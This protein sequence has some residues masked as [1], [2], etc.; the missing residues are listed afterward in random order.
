MS[1]EIPRVVVVGGGFGG[2][3]AAKT[4][5]H[6]PADVTLCDRNNY[7]L[8]QPLLYQVATGGLAPGEIAAPIRR[9]VRGQANISVL[10]ENVDDIDLERKEVVHRDGPIP[11]DY[12]IVATGARHAYFG[13]EGWEAAAPG[14]KTIEDAL[15][16]RRRIYLAY[17]EAERCPDPGRLPG[18]LDF[19]VIGGGPTGVELAGAI[20]EIARRTLRRD[21]RRIDPTTSRVI[22]I[23]AGSRVLPSF[24]PD[25]S[26]RAQATLEAM[27]VEV[28]LGT[29]VSD[30]SPEGVRLGDEWIESRTVIWAAGVE[31]SPLGRSLGP[32][33]DRAGRIEVLP[34]L[35]L[36]GHP[37]VFLVGDLALARG[38]NG[39]V[40][41][42]LAPVA[43]QEGR[44]AARN[45]IRRIAGQPTQ[46]FVYHDRGA[47]A[48]IGRRAA[49]AEIRGLRLTGVLAWLTWLFVHILYLIGFDN[50]IAVLWHWAYAY[51]TFERADRLITEPRTARAAPR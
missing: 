45:V 40:M 25:L 28:R 16:I 42:G 41:P 24:P 27:G 4:L 6:A 29:A 12:L 17:E 14:L 23:E 18:L 10:L 13:H 39:G 5:R 31:A 37:E 44:L 36:P 49:V 3:E 34:D 32:P 1:G 47:L 19:V 38:A 9:V 20:A 43:M 30:V 46:P 22:L 50:R 33:A 26:R 7:H 48:T 21:F 15:D 35:S 51:V 8:F 2:L 11:Y